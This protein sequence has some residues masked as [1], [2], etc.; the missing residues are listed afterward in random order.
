M[1]DSHTSELGNILCERHE[2]LDFVAIIKKETVSLRTVKDNVNLTDIAKQFG[3]GG[4]PK[5]SGFPLNNVKLNNFINDIF[6]IK[7]G[8]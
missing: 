8:E 5:A 4:H 6:D 7:E 1:A 3:G 2:E